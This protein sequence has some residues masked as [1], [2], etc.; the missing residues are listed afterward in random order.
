VCAT[1]GCRPGFSARSISFEFLKN[2]RDASYSALD[3]RSRLYYLTRQ[4]MRKRKSLV[5][6]LLA[7]TKSMVQGGLSETFRGCGKSTCPCH[8]DPAYRHGPH[9]YLTYR[10]NGASRSLYVPPEQ[11]DIARSAHD[12]WAS[13]WTI[14]CALAALN[15]EEL[16]RQ[17]QRKPAPR[18][19]RARRRSGRGH[20]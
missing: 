14:G 9:L 10:D 19:A 5:R 4:Y 20:D 2:L 15:R 17:W 8:D 7:A 3:S 11:A 6:A 1:F 18:A 16:R 12:A 13:F